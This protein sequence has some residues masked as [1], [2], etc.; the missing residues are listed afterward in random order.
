DN[1]E[2]LIIRCH[3][4]GGKDEDEKVEEDQFLRALET[5]LC[6]VKGVKYV[7]LMEQDKVIVTP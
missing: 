1:S 7:F 6:G 5:S 3:V 4:L 2:K